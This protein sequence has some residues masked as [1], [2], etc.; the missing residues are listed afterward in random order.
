MPGS[1]FRGLACVGLGLCLGSACE[2]RSTPSAASGREQAAPAAHAHG[3]AHAEHAQAHAKSEPQA[4]SA[5]GARR[6]G[7]EPQLAGPPVP[8]EQLLAE[9]DG[10]L[11]KAVQCEGKVARV[12][13]NAGCWLE[14]QPTA[15]GDGLRVPMANHAFF[16]PQDA[17]G[18]LA[19][20]E[21]ALSRQ[22]LPAAQREHYESEGMQAVGPL[23][24]EATSV[25][26]R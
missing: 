18:R 22:P 5:D 17:V 4:S 3:E 24:L 14:L 11:G 1:I 7:A 13:Q 8:V 19:V 20:V 23:S 10:H 6:F 9:P 2:G 25:V 16:I 15:G 12:C 21:G 26:L